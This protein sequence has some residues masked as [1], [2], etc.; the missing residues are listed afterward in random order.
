MTSQPSH[1]RPAR[2]QQSAVFR[3][4]EP[5]DANYVYCPNQ[6]LDVC[7]PNCSRGA[8]RI[9]AYLLR[10]TLGWLDEQGNPR[11]QDIVVTYNDL[12]NKAGV[13][14]G[15]ISAA[16][17]EAVAGGFI[18]RCQEAS[19]RS[20]GTAGQS[21]VYRLRWDATGKYTKQSE[22]FA[23]FYGGEGH[24]TP[25]PNTF[26]DQVVP[27]EPL[28][29]VKVVGTV[30]R[31]TV[32]YQNQFG[33][34]RPCAPLSF[35]RI[36]QYAKLSDR[37]TLT[38]AIRKAQDVGYIRCIESGQFSADKSNQRAA[39]YS[40]CWLEKAR[41]GDDGSKIRPEADQL[42]KPTS[43]GSETRPKDRFKNQTSKKTEP[44]NTLKQQQAAAVDLLLQAGFDRDAAVQLAG[45]SSLE[46]IENQITWLEAR[47][48]R[49][50][51]LG[52]L[53]KAIQ[54]DWSPPRSVELKF[55]QKRQR[56]RDQQRQQVKREEEGHIT[57]EKKERRKRKERLLV[58]WGSA[59]LK[60][61]QQWVTAAI[62]IEPSAT[63][64][65]IIKRQGT[66]T[67][68]PHV[69]V[70]NVIAKERGLSP[71]FTVKPM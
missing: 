70:L 20:A 27:C 63:L 59:P 60:Q 55:E 33:G 36:L 31:Y 37:T 34:R 3:G 22:R 61:R 39:T 7:L 54:E 69:N 1:D 62:D 65:D 66:D 9:V 6:F 40:V 25:I 29:V 11:Q 67:D 48:P 19:A 47:N 57:A 58:E 35:N 5:L 16:L 10:Q 12:I 56:Q 21:A 38:E 51:R 68:S 15:A 50:N 64:S 42:K 28:S 43:N 32:G 49:D 17:N 46:V 23:G 2:K 45:E 71:V 52:M 44:N 18:E 41:T 8:V 30:L 26:F 4:F 13:S 24:R 14:R 53:R